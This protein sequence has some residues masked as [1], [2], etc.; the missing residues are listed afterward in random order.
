MHGEF[1]LRGLDAAA[2][3]FHVLPLDRGLDVL[4]GQAARGERRAV[5]PDP[6]G[7]APLAAEIDIGHAVDRREAVHVDALEE[8]AQFERVVGVRGDASPT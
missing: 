5:D 1:A 3:Q 2:R 7:V 8:I 6:H 4:R